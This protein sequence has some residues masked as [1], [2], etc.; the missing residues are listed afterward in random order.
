MAGK[1]QSFLTSDELVS[2]IF[3]G[4]DAAGQAL[5]DKEFEDCGFNGCNFTDTAFTNCKFVDCTFT[6]CN[7]SNAKI[8]ATRF[9]NV[10]FIEC[11]V[12][13][14]DWTRAAWPRVAAGAL[15]Q[16][17]KSIL[18]DATFLGLTLEET[19]IEDCKAH[20][21]DFRD[22]DFARSNFT[23]TDFRQALFG[24]TNLSEA[25][26]SGA[27]NYAIDV[28]DNR[29]ERARF[30]RDAALSLLESLGIELVD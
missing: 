9:A 2:E 27:S 11:K 12:L 18:N 19:V 30:S 4:T 22:A 6:Q 29:I 17:R 8:G 24:K 3:R 7:L 10:E 26:F 23:G 5:H 16:F 20:G 25:N 28:F 15:L 13:G 21:V 1:Q 14:I